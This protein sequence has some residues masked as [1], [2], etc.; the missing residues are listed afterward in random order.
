MGRQRVNLH[1]KIANPRIS[2]VVDIK[3]SYVSALIPDVF[4]TGIECRTAG[5]A[6]AARQLLA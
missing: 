2:Q 6:D 3:L 1:Q 4:S 5:N